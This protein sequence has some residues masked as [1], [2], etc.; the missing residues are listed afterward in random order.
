MENST[1][2]KYKTVKD[3]EK[4]FGIYHYVAESSCCAKITEIG[5]SILGGQRGE[6]LVFFYS[7]TH[8]QT[9][10]QFLSSRLHITNMDRIERI[11]AHNTWFQ[12]HVPFGGLDDDQLFFGV[13]TPKKPKICISSHFCKKF[14]SLYLQNCVSD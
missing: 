9:H 5:S 14:K 11:N 3:I 8:R 2:C 4:P 10:K 6:V 7:Q 12:V 13:Q 1:P